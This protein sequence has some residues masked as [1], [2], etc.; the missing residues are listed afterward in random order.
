MEDGHV[1]EACL[2]NFVLFLEKSNI[3]KGHAFDA[4]QLYVVGFFFFFR[5]LSDSC[6]RVGTL[7][8]RSLGMQQQV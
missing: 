4:S 8:R 2:Q 7:N 5:S 6:L 3:G 1:S